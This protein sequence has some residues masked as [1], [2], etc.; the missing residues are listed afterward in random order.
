MASDPLTFSTMPIDE[1]KRRAREAE[2]LFRVA[3]ELARDALQDP[4]QSERAKD[5]IC[6]IVREIEELFPGM[7]ELGADVDASEL[8]APS[9]RREGGE[10][11]G[12]GKQE[13]PQD[14]EGEEEEEEAEDD[15]DG[16]DEEDDEEWDVD[17]VKLSAAIQNDE[18]MA[19]IPEV[20]RAWFKAMAQRVLDARER[21]GI[22]S[23]VRAGF[24]ELTQVS[25]RGLD[26]VRKQLGVALTL[27]SLGAKKRHQD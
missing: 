14:Q 23:R 6:A 16:V 24:E 12:E 4:Q 2:S 13:D 15:E 17:P 20:D 3:R 27:E 5:R 19:K 21:M 8:V 26:Q 22:I 11:E 25:Q 9:M 1:L 10:V 18:L 7:S